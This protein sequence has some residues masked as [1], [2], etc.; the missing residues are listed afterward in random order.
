MG[1]E[2][3]TLKNVVTCNKCNQ[4]EYYLEMRWFNGHEMCRSC[5]RKTW[6][7]ETGETY[8]WDD[9]DGEVPEEWARLS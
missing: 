7:R 2:A 1:M 4:L 9:L 6:E 5:Y 3:A 8:R